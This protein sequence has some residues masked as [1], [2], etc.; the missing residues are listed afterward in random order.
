MRLQE[1][2]D[3]MKNQFESSAPP[4]A[5]AMMHRATDELRKSGIMERVLKVSEQAPAFTLPNQNGH[6]VSASAL[7]DT[8]P[9]VIGFYRGV[10]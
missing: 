3:K 9:L 4:E 6:P 8:G 10:W 5:L 7:L 1:K 2:L